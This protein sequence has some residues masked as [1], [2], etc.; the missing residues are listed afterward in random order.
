MSSCTRAHLKSWWLFLAVL[1]RK[2]FLLVNLELCNEKIA[3][4]RGGSFVERH[5]FAQNL[6][7]LETLPLDLADLRT[8]CTQNKF[9]LPGFGAVIVSK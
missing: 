3:G 6:V 7:A 4:K 1:E 9:V 5:V 8:L 2:F